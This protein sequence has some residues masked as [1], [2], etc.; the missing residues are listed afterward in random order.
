MW[1]DFYSAGGFGM[2]P[3]T[4]FGFLMVAAAALYAFRMR[5]QHAKLT[6]VLGGMTLMAG[7]L[8]TSTGIC[9]SA[10]YIHK[11]D[12]TKQLGILALGVQES[13][14]DLVLAL[15]FV[16]IAGLFACAGIVRDARLKA[17]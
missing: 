9:N 7:L 12:V 10:F 15:I 4:L 1:S 13:L 16:L 17:A 11:V 2:Y 8:G 5:A 3:V 14:H 6:W